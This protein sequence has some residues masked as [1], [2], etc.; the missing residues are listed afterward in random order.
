VTVR[1]RARRI[2]CAILCSVWLVSCGLEIA[3]EVVAI[4]ERLGNKF[5][6]T[7]E[8]IYRRQSVHYVT[9]PRFKMYRL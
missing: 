9:R 2:G 3:E 1:V 7:G 5:T 4:G 8:I 6:L